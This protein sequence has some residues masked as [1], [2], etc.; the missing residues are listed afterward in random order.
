MLTFSL[1]CA[2]TLGSFGSIQETDQALDAA[3]YDLAHDRVSEAMGGLADHVRFEVSRL[4]DLSEEEAQLA[5]DELEVALIVFDRI[6]QSLSNDG[7][8]VGL[9]GDIEVPKRFGALYARLAWLSDA[10]LDRLDPLLDWQIVGPFDNERGRGMV[11]P[12]A[13]EKKPNEE[14]YEGKVRDV[15]WRDLPKVA[16]R[17]GVVHLGVLAK[18]AQ[19]AA[20]LAR[21]WVHCDQAETLHLM[22]GASEELRVWLGGKPIFEALGEHAFGFDTH[23]IPLQMNAGWNELVFKV[24][25]HEGSPMFQARLVEMDTGAPVK[26]ETRAHAPEG[27]EPLKLDNPGRRIKGPVSGLRAGAWRRYAFGEGAEASF[28]LGLIQNNAQP[29]PRSERAGSEAAAAAHG[30]DDSSLR[31]HIL[32]IET[33]REMGA[34]A[35]EEDIN[36]Y[37]SA[38]DL[39]IQHHGDLPWLLR[40]RARH[41]MQM[42]NSAQMAL[43]W[44]ERAVAA[45]PQ[46]FLVRRDHAW[47]VSNLGLG[48]R[49][50]AMN[51]QLVRDPNTRDW[52]GVASN[53]TGLLPRGSKERADWLQAGVAAGNRNMVR[54]QHAER[55]LAEQDASAQAYL[56][57]LADIRKLSPWGTDEGMR[58]VRMLQSAG[59]LGEA[60]ELLTEL[61]DFSPD[62]AAMHSLKARIAW[63][64]GD[65]ERAVVSLE[66]S[67]ELDFGREEERRLLK[68]L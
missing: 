39:A 59:H 46:S 54:Q 14:T 23:T 1:A 2:L 65:V 61:L 57:E 67:L 8:R 36:P 66:R 24:G 42:Q 31:Y 21:T 20:V 34:S 48:A 55:R 58:T 37:L 5:A 7:V 27:V 43:P 30:S 47:I 4:A 18:P 44:I 62:D 40:L 29:V 26:R 17:G 13:A 22:A 41:A 38:L 28:R 35:V 49:A 10:E 45:N 12:T 32:A 6:Q 11:R 63:A 25:S 68:Y 56:D 52:V 16:P 51:R 50:Q 53:L 15:S 19:Q 64:S 3:Y 33:S 60:N 9:V